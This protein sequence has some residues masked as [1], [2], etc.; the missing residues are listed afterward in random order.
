MDSNQEKC[1]KERLKLKFD[2]ELNLY[3]HGFRKIYD[4]KNVLDFYRI[5]Q[6]ISEELVPQKIRAYAEKWNLYNSESSKK[7]WIKSSE[8]YKKFRGG[9]FGGGDVSFQG[10][11]PRL[12]YGCVNW[13]FNGYNNIFISISMK[14]IESTIGYNKFLELIKRLFIWC[15]GFYG[16][17]KH[18][19]QYSIHSTPGLDYETCIGGISWLTLFGAPYVELFG[20][21]TLKTVPCIAEEFNEDQFLLLTSEEPIE[22]TPEL[23][24]LQ[25]RV[26]KHLGEDAFFRHAEEAKRAKMGYDAPDETGYRAPDFAKWYGTTLDDV[27]NGIVRENGA[28][29]VELPDEVMQKSAQEVVG[30]AKTTFKVKLD[31]SEKSIKEVEKILAALYESITPENKPTDN[32]LQSAAMLWGSYIGEVIRRNYG[33]EWQKTSAGIIFKIANAELYPLDK[34]YKRLTNGVE[35]N[36]EF[37]YET[38]KEQALK[39]IKK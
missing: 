25:E 35:D 17:G 8:I 18:P 1:I 37:Y 2:D 5:F 3:I 27:R 22:A 13:E 30:F 6:E 24:A 14:Y 11:K 32:Q 10:K 33:G 7:I 36:I 15:N 29:E 20:K 12:Y 23:L 34:V 19:S 21:E 4:E 39:T 31:F 9:I 28:N 16:Y 38:F 26:R